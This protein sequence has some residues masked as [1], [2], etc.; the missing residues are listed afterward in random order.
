LARWVRGNVHFLVAAG[1]LV[2]ATAVWFTAIKTQLIF[3]VKHPVPWPAFEIA[4]DGQSRLWK[5]EVS[6]D[7]RWTNLAAEFGPFHL[8]GEDDR[9]NGSPIAQSGEIVYSD[10]VLS[11]LGI[12]SE[13]NEKQLADRASNWYVSRLYLD[14]RK[15]GS[16]AYSSPYAL[17]HLDVTYYTGSVDLVPHTPDACLLAAGRQI[18]GRESVTFDVAVPDRWKKWWDGKVAFTRISSELPGAVKSRSVD[19]FAFSLNGR[20]ETDRLVVRGTLTLPW[21]PHCYFAKIQFTPRTNADIADP[22]EADQAAEEFV[23]NFLPEVLR[24][25]PTPDDVKKLKSAR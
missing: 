11:A 14:R 1:I 12:A 20:P 6:K 7:S 19:Y 22:K 16:N 5:Q 9:L 10:D 2:L 25:M 23:R 21:V 3:P 4:V 8:V 13:L 17:W 15:T 18:T 24:G